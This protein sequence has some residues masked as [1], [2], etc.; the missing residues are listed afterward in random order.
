MADLAA[1]RPHLGDRVRVRLGPAQR[2]TRTPWH[3]RGRDAVV[4]AVHGRFPDADSLAHG[5]VA[6]ETWLVRVRLIESPAGH[7]LEADVYASWLHTVASP[8]D[9]TD[10]LSDP[11]RT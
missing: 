9:P 6:Q 4:V 1:S 3:V 11:R 7:Q 10:P 5:E 8:D 2:Y